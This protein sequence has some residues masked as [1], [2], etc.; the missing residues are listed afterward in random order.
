MVLRTWIWGSLALGVGY[1]EKGES[2]EMGPR[3]F[4]KSPKMPP[5]GFGP[6]T[7]LK[8][9][10]GLEADISEAPWTK[11]TGV[12][13]TRRRAPRGGPRWP[14]G[15]TFPHFPPPTKS[16]FG[17]PGPTLGP[18]GIPIGPRGGSRVNRA[19]LLAGAGIAALSCSRSS[20]STS[21]SER[22]RVW[23][24]ASQTVCGTARLVS[25]IASQ[26]QGD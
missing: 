13:L 25:S 3:V 5:P 8:I 14:W 20:W 16:R 21:Y 9:V 11:M 10:S 4:Q 12:A 7:T 6:R 18:R 19:W 15:P 26:N 23:P 1:F 22:I 24:V 17:P 2:P